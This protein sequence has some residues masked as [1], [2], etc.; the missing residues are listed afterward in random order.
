MI[1][2]TYQNHDFFVFAVN[3]FL[4]HIFGYSFAPAVLNTISVM[5]NHFIVAPLGMVFWGLVIYRLYESKI[6]GS[7][8]GQVGKYTLSIYIMEGFFFYDYTGAFW[9]DIMFSTIL[10]IILPMLFDKLIL[11]V[12]ACM[13]FVLFGSYK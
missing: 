12:S 10:G 13:H 11:R 4:T 8:F 6:L 5:Y 3:S 7:K 1:L 2:Y 9:L